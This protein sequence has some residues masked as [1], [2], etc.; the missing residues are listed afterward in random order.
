MFQVNNFILA[1]VLVILS[2]CSS[3]LSKEEY[4]AWFSNPE[5]PLRVNKDIGGGLF[6]VQYKTPQAMNLSCKN[7]SRMYSEELE[8]YQ[9]RWKDS[10]QGKDLELLHYLS[11][12]LE[13]DLMMEY[14]DKQEPV[15]LYHFERSYDLGNQKSILVA[16]EKPK[17]ECDRVLIFDASKLGAGPLRFVFTAKNISKL[18]MLKNS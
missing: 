2:S 7:C 13:N 18:P 6:E 4:L 17:H 9:I 15:A 5:N 11:Y 1:I 8:F 10:T 14:Q 16:F 12:Q 3:N